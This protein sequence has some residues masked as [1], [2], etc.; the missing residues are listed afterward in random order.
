MA[1]RF[2]HLAEWTHLGLRTGQ[3]YETK[4]TPVLTRE[5]ERRERSRSD[6]GLTSGNE[7]RNQEARD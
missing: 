7:S 6:A 1:T 3:N 5:K 4:A 2:H